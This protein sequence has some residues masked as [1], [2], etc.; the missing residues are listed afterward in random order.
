MVDSIRITPLLCTSCDV[1]KFWAVSA[2]PQQ[3]F[4]L[5]MKLDHTS[6]SHLTVQRA[7]IRLHSCINQTS[8]NGGSDHTYPMVVSMEN[9]VPFTLLTAVNCT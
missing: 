6:F 4:P 3:H 5:Q 7:L 1:S 9:N 8:T 2:A